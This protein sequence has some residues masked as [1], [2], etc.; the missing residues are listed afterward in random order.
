MALKACEFLKTKVKDG[1]EILF[2]GTKKPAQDIIKQEAVRCGMFFV[3]QRWLGGTLTNFSTLQK[4]IGRF[5]EYRRLEETGDFGAATKK[6]ILQIKK[7]MEKMSKNMTGICD[8]KR[9]PAALFVV[10]PKKDE[11]A[12]REA[13]KL[14]IPVVSLIDTNGDP[15]M[16]DFI[17]AGNDDAAKSIKFVTSLVADAVLEGCKIYLESRP[18]EELSSEKEAAAKA[19]RAMEEEALEETEKIIGKKIKK[20]DVAVRIKKKSHVYGQQQRKGRK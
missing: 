14:S 6:E 19:G 4:S 2:V 7:Q 1:G 20:P 8:M 16:V 17:I 3:N 5:K 15:D 11:I 12:V 13:R 9:L 10:D 18:K